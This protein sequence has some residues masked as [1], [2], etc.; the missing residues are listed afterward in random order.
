MFAAKHFNR[1][2]EYKKG[3]VSIVKDSSIANLLRIGGGN[4]IEIGAMYAEWTL[5]NPS[6]FVKNIEKK[7]GFALD[8]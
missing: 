5:K 4:I 8:L 3:A 2:A 1:I 6:V 7:K